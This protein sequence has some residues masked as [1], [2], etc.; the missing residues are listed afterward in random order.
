MKN[1][2]QFNVQKSTLRSLTNS[3]INHVA[4][5]DVTTMT[6]TQPTVTVDTITTGNTGGMPTVTTPRTTKNQTE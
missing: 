4:G 3:E 1:K 6:I 2:K 5:G